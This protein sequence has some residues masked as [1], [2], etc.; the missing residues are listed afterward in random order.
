MNTALLTSVAWSG[1]PAA[2]LVD[3][4]LVPPDEAGRTGSSRNSALQDRNGR[5]DSEVGSSPSWLSPTL[6]PPDMPSA[7]VAATTVPDPMLAAARLLLS[8]GQLQAA[9]ELLREV[10]HQGIDRRNAVRLSLAAATLDLEFTSL[11]ARADTA[12]DR[13]H[14]GDAEYLYWRS[15]ALYPLHSGYMV[16]YGHALK[17]QG[18]L[19]DAE[20][21]YRSAL[22][23]GETPADLP[24]HIAHVASLLGHQTIPVPLPLGVPVAPPLLPLDEAPCRDDIELAFALLLHRPA[25]LVEEI[26]PL[27]REARTRR[28]VLLNLLAGN[29]TVVANR[30]LMLLLAQT[31]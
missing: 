26:L 14:W 1:R 30:D 19:P 18:K 12:R 7:E 8:Q 10:P 23:L 27:M 5:V 13:Q 28:A 4:L 17:E 15:L 31:T 24:D 6:D 16:Q 2:T 22:A 21:A 11:I 3:Q 25:R 29:D 9:H 20:V